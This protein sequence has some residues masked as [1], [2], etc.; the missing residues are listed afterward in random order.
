[1]RISDWS[2]DVCSSDLDQLGSQHVYSA[3]DHSQTHTPRQ[4]VDGGA[5]TRQICTNAATAQVGPTEERSC[6][7]ID[8][9]GAGR[10]LNPEFRSVF[11]IDLHDQTFDQHLRTTLIE[12]IDYLAQAAVQRDRK[13]TRLNSSH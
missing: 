8:V 4:G 1:M 10:P 2:S 12:Q 5:R 3:P 13:S 11:G 9:I 6:A 7:A